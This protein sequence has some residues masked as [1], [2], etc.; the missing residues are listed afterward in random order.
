MSLAPAVPFTWQDA[1]WTLAVAIL[2]NVSCALLGCYLVLRRL[3]LLGDAISHSVLPGIALAFL[4]TQR[5]SGWPII[6]GA[7]LLG[8]L[9]TLL[10]QTV[11]QLGKVAEDASM[12]VVFTSLFALGVLLM[13]SETVRNVDIDASCV[14]YGL[15]E[16][17]SVNR[18]TWLGLRVPQALL[19]LGPM[20][21]LTIAFVLLL[22]K[23]LK[24]AS[25]DPALAT[26]LGFNAGGIHYLLMAMVAAVTVASFEAVGSILVVAMLIVPAATA[27]LLTDRL[28]WMMVVAVM[29]GI[30]SALMGYLITRY[31][32]TSLAG[33]M[34]VMAG[35]QFALAV[36]LAPRHGV[37]SKIRR[38]TL[39][40]VRIRR[41]DLLAWLYRREEQAAQPVPM[42]LTESPASVQGLLGKLAVLSAR[43]QG[44]IVQQGERVQLTEAGRREAV[45]V[46]RS[47]RLWEAFLTENLDLPLDHLHEPAEQMEHFIGPALQ[48]EIT[49]QLGQPERDPHGKVIPRS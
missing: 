28:H 10:T 40:A 15:I 37:L 35:L 24:L 47:H 25:F 49:A 17:V 7:M 2:C 29:V 11:T 45:I 48:Q 21:L 38:N 20:M 44:L 41:E 14:L 1:G 4:L 36:F 27:H 9:T 43:S 18:V 34:A 8:L 12:G 42:G 16:T 39:L 5:I 3:S 13:S 19:T 23:E 22:W 30:V 26:A 46:V 31:V 33:M 6:L 32:S